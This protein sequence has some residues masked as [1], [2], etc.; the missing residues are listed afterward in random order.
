MKEVNSGK[1]NEISNLGTTHVWLNKEAG[2]DFHSKWTKGSTFL[3]DSTVWVFILLL[4][5]GFSI[6]LIYLKQKTSQ[7]SKQII[8]LIPR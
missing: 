6:H 3:I 1:H 5:K 4:D 7:I 8:S 2:M